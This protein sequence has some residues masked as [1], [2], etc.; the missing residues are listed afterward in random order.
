MFKLFELSIGDFAIVKE[1]TNTSKMPMQ[2]HGYIRMIKEEKDGYIPIVVKNMMSKELIESE[3]IEFLK[4][5]AV[6]ITE[7]DVADEY[8]D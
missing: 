8:S 1:G 3:E 6:R 2:V 4:V 7:E 5:D